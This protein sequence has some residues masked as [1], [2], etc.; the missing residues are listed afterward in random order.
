MI[1]HICKINY[2]K[3]HY[4]KGTTVKT[5][6]I[7]KLFSKKCLTKATSNRQIP[8]SKI[9]FENI[10]IIRIK[11]SFRIYYLIHVKQKTPLRKKRGFQKERRRHTLPHNCSTICA[12]GLNY[13]VRDG[14]R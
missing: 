14:K 10:A 2:Q 3:R 1:E 7:M 4:I 8:Y 6:N 11:A 9:G 12:G 5:A 13:S